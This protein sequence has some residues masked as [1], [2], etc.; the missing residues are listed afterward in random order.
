MLY[1]TSD[2]REL[3]RDLNAVLEGLGYL[4]ENMVPDRRRELLR[5]ILNNP[6]EGEMDYRED[7]PM[8]EGLHPSA[9]ALLAFFEYKH[10]PPGLAAISKSCHDLA[11]EMAA[12]PA[13]NGPEL[14]VGLR[15]LLEAKDCFVRAAL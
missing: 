6:E 9:R 14:T 12:D 11:H 2:V 15:K 1:V 5:T 13:L 10:L 7:I 8:R 4:V 3:V